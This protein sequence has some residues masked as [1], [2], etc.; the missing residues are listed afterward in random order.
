ML[1]CSRKNEPPH[2]R[3]T[4]MLGRV[5]RPQDGCCKQPER[6]ARRRETTN[7]TGLVWQFAR[8]FKPEFTGCRVEL[9]A[10]DAPQYGWW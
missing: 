5:A 8:A 7:D 1:V 10:A 3:Q 9:A 6:T 4:L 2:V